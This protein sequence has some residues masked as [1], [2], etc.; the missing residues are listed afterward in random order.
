MSLRPWTCFSLKQP[1]VA[2]QQQ[3]FPSDWDAPLDK[4]W[5]QLLFL[6]DSV[7]QRGKW[8]PRVLKPNVWQNVS[9]EKWTNTSN[10]LSY[11]FL[12]E[13]PHTRSP[14]CP[15]RLGI[16]PPKLQKLEKLAWTCRLAKLNKYS[17]YISEWW[18]V[19]FLAFKPQFTA[20]MNR[21]FEF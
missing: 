12:R 11:K 9:I 13:K 8:T 21:S 3:H 14:S 1:F 6:F 7:H 16:T 10:W 5:F 18:V 15:N 19:N 4:L 17:I 2:V 20:N